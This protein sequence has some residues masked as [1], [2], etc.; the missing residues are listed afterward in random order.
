M[1]SEK[2]LMHWKS[3]LRGSFQMIKFLKNIF[4]STNYRLSLEDYSKWKKEVAFPLASQEA[5]SLIETMGNTYCPIARTNCLLQNCVHYRKPIINYQN[6]SNSLGFEPFFWV[7][8]PQCKLW[9]N[10]NGSN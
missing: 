6:G 2:E 8:P 10:L 9:G 7:D 5:D 1:L 4:K 3:K